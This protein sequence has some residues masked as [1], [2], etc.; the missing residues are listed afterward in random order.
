[1]IAAVRYSQ[2]SADTSKENQS[3]AEGRIKTRADETKASI[4]RREESEDRSPKQHRDKQQYQ[5]F[6]MTVFWF[7]IR[8]CPTKRSVLNEI[9]SLY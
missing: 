3:I 1:M 8:H 4:W 6:S 9:T 5:Y 7:Y 2:A